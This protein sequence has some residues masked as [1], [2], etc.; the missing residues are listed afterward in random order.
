MFADVQ[1]LPNGKSI[2]DDCHIAHPVFEGVVIDP[3][4]L[5]NFLEPEIAKVFLATYFVP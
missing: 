1:A 4:S 3:D 2:R 5:P